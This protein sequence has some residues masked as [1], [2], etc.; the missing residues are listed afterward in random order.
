M[1]EEQT[2]LA[3][4]TYV[5]EGFYSISIAELSLF[6]DFNDFSS[7]IIPRAFSLALPLCRGPCMHSIRLLL[8]TPTEITYIHDLTHLHLQTSFSSYLISVESEHSKF[9]H[10]PNTVVT[11]DLPISGLTTPYPIHVPFNLPEYYFRMPVTPLILPPVSLHGLSTP[12]LPYLKV[13]TPLFH[14]IS[15]T[16]TTSYPGPSRNLRL[17]VK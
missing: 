3:L 15:T 11:S 2:P 5:L 4:P 6:S 17:W 16:P 10:I 9:F 8:G 7:F 12:L 14:K 1:W 13:I